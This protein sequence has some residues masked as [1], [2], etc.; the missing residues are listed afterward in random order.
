MATI[1]VV[2]DDPMLLSNLATILE[3]EG[4]SVIVSLN[5][6]EAIESAAQRPVDLILC[7]MIMEPT[8]GFQVLQAI[9]NNPDTAHIPLIFVTAV[10]WDGIAI[11][12]A[13]GY[14]MKPFTNEQLLG[15]IQ[16]Q[17]GV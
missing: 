2:D 3:F 12:G 11:D 13:S 7:D 17:L 14:I 15:A 10:D 5:G 6:T 4:F 16:E 1:L 8:N 9:R